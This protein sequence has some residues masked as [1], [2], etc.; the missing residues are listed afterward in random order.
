M[1][2]YTLWSQ[3]NKLMQDAFSEKFENLFDKSIRSNGK[4]L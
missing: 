2:I 4:L 3:V 1:R